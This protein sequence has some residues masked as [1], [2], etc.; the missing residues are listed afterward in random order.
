[1]RIYGEELIYSGAWVVLIG[2]AIAAVG[3]TK[4]TTTESPKGSKLVAQGNMVEAF[5]NSLQALGNEKLFLEEREQFQ[6][7]TITG[8]WL[9]TVGNITN[10]V[11]TNIEMNISK[12]EGAGLNAVGSGI[13]G[14]G[15]IYEAMGAAEGSSP[16][17]NWK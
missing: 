10:T 1:M 8:A 16:I 2:T 14:L 17:N 11:A 7:N 13:Q 9:Q 6:I 4:V 15:A 3:Q 5:G 12:E